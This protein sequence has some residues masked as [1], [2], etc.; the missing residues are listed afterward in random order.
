MKTRIFTILTALL[1]ACVA[2]AQGIQD[3]F[4]PVLTVDRGWMKVSLDIPS[5]NMKLKSCETLII[6]P[7]IATSNEVTDLRSIAIFGRRNHI[8]YERGNYFSDILPEN[9]Y[10]NGKLPDTILY[11]DSIPSPKAA[12]GAQCG[13]RL[14]KFG[15][16]HAMTG[17]PIDMP[18]LSIWHTPTSGMETAAL[19]LAD[20]S[21]MVEFIQPVT[22]SVKTRSFT[23]RANVEF[24]VNQVVL[25]EDFRKNYSELSTIKS[26]IDSVRNDPDVNVSSIEICG[27]ASPEG[28]YANNDRL[29]GGRAKAVVDYVEALCEMQKGTIRARHVP[30]DWAGL[31]RWVEVS[32]LSSRDAILAIID[33]TTLSPDEKDAKIKRRHPSDYEILYR[34]VYPSLR[35]T[36]YTVEYTV[37]TYSDPQEILRVMKTRPGNLSEEEFFIAAQSL[38]PGSPEF[39]EVFDI[40]VRIYPDNETANLNAANAAL[41]RRDIAAAER[42]LAKAGSSPQAQ[43]ARKALQTLKT[44]DA[45]SR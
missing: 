8:Q 18:G 4:F 37:R 36:D 10:R 29:A 1:L 31:R 40:A 6:T 42:Y 20:I 19:T 39:N 23:G 30:E 32:N 27:Y 3:M 38:E 22:E 41:L 17:D 25:I 26:G 15:C 13:V 34:T 33:D 5:D 11:A 28:G 35:H 14:E 24:E 45:A 2:S 43:K 7:Y 12:D 16:A 21:G 44:H 9:A